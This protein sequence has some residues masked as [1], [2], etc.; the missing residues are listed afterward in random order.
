[1][2]TMKIRNINGT[3]QNSC[4]CGSWLTHWEKFSG[5]R[6]PAFCPTAGCYNKDLVGAHVQV[7][8]DSDWYIF[9]LCTACNKAKGTLEVSS[10]YRLVS[11]N[12]A[13]TCG[14]RS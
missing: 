7:E 4:S 6:L 13:R 2:G 12:K 8:G 14:K 3:S 1:V 11:A 10:T 5:M 9:P